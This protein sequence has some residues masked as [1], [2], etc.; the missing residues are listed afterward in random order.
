MLKPRRWAF[1]RQ[2]GQQGGALIR[3]SVPLGGETP[4]AP[5]PAAQW[6]QGKGVRRLVC[7]QMGSHQTGDLLAPAVGL[8]AA[9]L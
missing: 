1:E 4:R 7:E 5:T 8:S 9:R 3:G 6:G 2:L